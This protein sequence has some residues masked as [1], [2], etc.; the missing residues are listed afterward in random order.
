MGVAIDPFKG[1]NVSILI[2][3]LGR[4][5]DVIFTLP[6]VIALKKLRPEIEIDW[7]VEDRCA[8]LLV[9]HPAINNLIIFPRARYQSLVKQKKYRQAWG[10][11]VDLVRSIRTRK[12]AAVLDFQGQ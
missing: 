9:G 1:K 12:Y 11:L 4:I 8:D 5:G 10:I 7:V 2:V 3:L 6:S